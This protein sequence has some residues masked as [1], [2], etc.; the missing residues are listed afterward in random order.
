MRNADSGEMADVTIVGAGVVGL[1]IAAEL[2]SAQRTVVVLE[3]NATFGLE[4]SSHNS[5]VIHAGLYYPKE[6]LMARL[7]LEGNRRLY[8][9]CRAK[10]VPHRRTGKL[11][12]ATMDEEEAALL[13]LR[14]RAQA[15][16]VPSLEM[17]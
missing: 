13:A 15:N 6:S 9:Y 5:G 4:T 7:C 14:D 3:R 10:G 17:L 11:V 2:A 8:E 16:G 1:A 12:V